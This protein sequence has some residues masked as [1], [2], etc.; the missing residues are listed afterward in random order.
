MQTAVEKNIEQSV[1]LDYIALFL[2]FVCTGVCI[3]VNRDELVT[4]SEYRMGKINI[5]ENKTFKFTR[6]CRKSVTTCSRLVII[7]AG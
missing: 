2:A 5:A 3:P 6:N 1:V 7:R 4:S